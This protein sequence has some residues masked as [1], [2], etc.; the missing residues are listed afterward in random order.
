MNNFNFGQ[1]RGTVMINGVSYAGNNISVVGNKV[2]IDGKEQTGSTGDDK[3]VN[4]TVN[5]DIHELKVG[6]AA[7]VIVT[8]NCEIVSVQ[9]GNVAITGYVGGDVNNVNGDIR[10]GSVHGSVKTVNGDIRHKSG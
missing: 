3:I 8:G 4:I 10:C 5:G 7:D 1:S 6:N 9:N 2:I